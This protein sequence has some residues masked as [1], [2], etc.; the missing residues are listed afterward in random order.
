MSTKMPML[1]SLL[2]CLARVVLVASGLVS[3][4]W[5]TWDDPVTVLL[6]KECGREYSFF[7]FLFITDH[8][9]PLQIHLRLL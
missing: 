8:D 7:L 6:L 4:Q 5:V 9:Q 1:S 2:L 3:G